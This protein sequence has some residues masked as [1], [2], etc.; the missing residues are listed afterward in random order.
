MLFLVKFLRVRDTT[1]LGFLLGRVFKPHIHEQ[2]V[3]FTNTNPGGQRIQQSLFYPTPPPHNPLGSIYD[4]S[5][6]SSGNV[7]I[8]DH[9]FRLLHLD[10]QI[11][12]FFHKSFVNLI[13]FKFKRFS[14]YSIA[15]S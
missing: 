15:L 3:S 6:R 1:F 8:K 10:E 9:N 5:F 14:I 2:V 7:L 13:I 12:I 11:K 4:P